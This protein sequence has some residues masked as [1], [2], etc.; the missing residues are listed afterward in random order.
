MRRDEV[1]K[2]AEIDHG[3]RAEWTPPKRPEW[4]ERLNGLTRA[5]DLGGLVPLDPAELIETATAN[6]GLSDFGSDDWR[7]PFE[8][9][10]RSLNHEANLNTTGRLLARADI[11]RLLEGRLRVE[12]A[13]RDHPEIE[14]ENINS[15]VFIVGQGRT[16]TSILQ[17]LLGLDPEN[18]TLMTWEAMF[19]CGEDGI[20]ERIAKA[21]AQFALW[22]GVA[23]EL[24][25]IHDW[26][27][28]EPIE[29]ILAEA[30]SFQC[31]AWLNLI[32]LTPSYNAIIT[33]DHR[34]RSLAYA[35]R[36]MKLCQ[37][38]R[39]GGRWV[40]KSPDATAYL[41][42]VVEVFEG[43]RLIWPHRDPIR[44]MSSAVNMIGNF[45][46]AR[47][48]VLPPSGVFDFMTD[49][50]AS[51]DRLSKPIDEI[52]SGAV[53]QGRLANIR[54]DE[55][56]DD[57]LA[58]LENTYAQIGITLGD[59]GRTAILDHF[60][61]NPQSERKQHSYHVGDRERIANERPFFARYQEYF[62]VPSEL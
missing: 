2:P 47:S 24:D 51:A 45:I 59:A 48:D 14:D 4:V 5:L 62:S 26:G 30:M 34:R 18:R 10:I 44:A 6:T 9:L 17:K 56:M 22:C 53:P 3:R 35:R 29:T 31:P 40:V 41:P 23:P 49:P 55:L 52:E 38:Q 12:K 54:Y 58:A 46:W 19:P 1:P 42:L 7:D 57:P 32:G 43:V 28:D 11:L 60:A 50:Q 36:V 27:G 25:R 61:G 16:G 13:Y 21:D 39:P 15:P 37:W 33:D 8:V 20:A